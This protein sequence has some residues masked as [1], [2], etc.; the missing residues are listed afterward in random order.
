MQRSHISLIAL[1]LVFATAGFAATA[2]AET[3]VDYVAGTATPGQ[4]M[5]PT[6]AALCQDASGPEGPSAGNP[7]VGGGCGLAVDGE[8]TVTVDDENQDGVGFTWLAYNA[9]GEVCADGSSSEAT[10][11]FDLP[12]ECETLNVFVGVGAT[13]GTITVA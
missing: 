9:D 12:A 1:S 13:T 2:A 11:T 6:G 3:S 7:G 8:T 5:V 4:P 10:S